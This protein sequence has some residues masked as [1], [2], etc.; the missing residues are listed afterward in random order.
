MLTRPMIA[1]ILQHTN[2]QS[3][4]CTLETNI[5][6]YVKLYLNKKKLELIRIRAGIQGKDA[7]LGVGR[8]GAYPTSII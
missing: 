3:L 5:T 7:G 1:I 6:L 2:M 8:P 4:S